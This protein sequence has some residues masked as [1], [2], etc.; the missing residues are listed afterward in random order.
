MNVKKNNKL[1]NFLIDEELFKSFHAIA[2]SK[3]TTATA[4]IRAYVI[5][6][7]KKFQAKDNTLSDNDKL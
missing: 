3:Y 1:V 6:E 2:A 4:L 7:V 5:R